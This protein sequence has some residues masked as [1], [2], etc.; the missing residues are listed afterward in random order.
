MPLIKIGYLLV[1]TVA[2][3]VAGIFKKQA[4]EHPW[5]RGACSRLA[6][7]YHRSE[8]KMKRRIASKNSDAGSELPVEAKIKPLDEQKA[9]DLGGTATT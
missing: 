8:V 6:Q 9:I 5:F 1:R 2:K 4:K 3:P 7:S